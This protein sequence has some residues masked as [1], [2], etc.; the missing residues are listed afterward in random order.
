MRY[1]L[2]AVL[3]SPKDVIKGDIFILCPTTGQPVP[4]GL[5]TDTVVFHTLPKVEMHMQCPACHKNHSWNRCP[6]SQIY[7]ISESVHPQQS[8]LPAATWTHHWCYVRLG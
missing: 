4:T 3:P 2:D 7:R 6:C 5:H 1:S 8:N